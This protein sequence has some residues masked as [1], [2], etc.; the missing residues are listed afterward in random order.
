M[1]VF[2]GIRYG[3]DTSARRFAPALAPRPWEHV[4]DAFEHGPACAQLGDDGP[5][6][7]DCLFL[8]VWTPAVA[9]GGARPVMV[10]IHGGAY[11]SGSGS[12]PVT[13]GA[14]L[15]RRGDV[16]VVTLNHRLNAF[17]YLYLDRFGDPGFADSG[18]CGQLDLVLAL[19]W[20]R[21]NAGSF[22]GDPA[23]V[24]VFG[25][26]GGGAKIATLM[27]MPSAAGLFHRAATMSGQQV[28]ASGPLNATS[29]A[30]VFLDALHLTPARV[31]ELRNVS[32][33][34]L[35]RALEAPDPVIGKGRL[36]FGPVLDERSL[37]RHPFYPDA[38]PQSAQIPMIIGNTR[39]ETRS[40]IGRND[41]T[42]FDLTWAALPERLAPEMRVD[43]RPE[44]V[45]AEYRR[46]YPQY[47]PSDVFF[48]ATTA[49]RS[50]RGAL[51]ELAARAQQGAPTWAY[52]LEFCSPV[53]SGKWGA[54]HGLD[55]PLVF[56]NCARPD[57]MTGTA[58]EAQRTAAAMSDAFVALAYTG[59][60][61]HRSIPRWDRH[62]L[63]ARRTLLFDADPRLVDDPRGV[64]R[65]LFEK[66]PF[67]QQGT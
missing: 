19:Q 46:A 21:A 54:F 56:D 31:A 22:G 25:Q 57:S 8:N 13:D 44:T 38:P 48:A 49:A 39:H 26:S 15:C 20:V 14:R 9:D 41:P 5:G 24:M 37:V 6:S 62:E 59:D 64:E 43:I 61:N 58:P 29:R 36:Y 67:V 47:S 50:W 51:I 34:R 30:R 52:H 3:E 35:L 28:T 16:V 45:I 40:L 42:T 4:V 7:E 10:Y 18:N 60:P 2:K 17:G 1:L 55:I 63:P 65:R 11:S 12:S 53:D 33:E 32:V 23:R 27:S 66:A